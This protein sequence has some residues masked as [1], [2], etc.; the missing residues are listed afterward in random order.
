MVLPDM[1][2]SAVGSNSAINVDAAAWLAR[3]LASTVDKLP[4]AVISILAE[5]FQLWFESDRTDLCSNRAGSRESRI[6]VF[7]RQDPPT[8]GRRLEEILSN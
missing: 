2:V 7:L 3:L 5:L 1:F 4:V 8:H 6:A